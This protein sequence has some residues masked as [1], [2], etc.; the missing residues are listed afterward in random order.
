MNN[1]PNEWTQEASTKLK[2]RQVREQFR[3]LASHAES[4]PGSGSS[5]TESPV[6]ELAANDIN[7]KSHL[8][9]L[10]NCAKCEYEYR[11]FVLTQNV[12]Y[13]AGSSEI[14]EPDQSWF[15][16]LS[17]RIAREGDRLGRARA[18]EEPWP[19]VVWETARQLI[20]V[21]AVLLLIIAGATILWGGVPKIQSQT[22]IRASD[23]VL[24][25]NNEAEEYPQPT[26]DDVLQTLVA[27]EERKN[28]K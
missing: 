15:L 24:F 2:C 23:R 26:A 20:P 8:L 13:T 7:P 25:N 21:M 3:F 16:A 17:A 9:H 27:V 6:S 1:T 11:L 22:S 12:L 5:V 19:T 28:G 4:Q 14:I 18:G 10:K